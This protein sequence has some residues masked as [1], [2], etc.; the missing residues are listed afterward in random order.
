MMNRRKYLLAMAAAL[1][2]CSDAIRRR[3]THAD[4]FGAMYGDCDS[5][6]RLSQQLLSTHRS[7]ASFG[8]AIIVTA[9][10]LLKIIYN[11]LKNGWI[12]EGFT[13]FETKQNQC[14]TDNHHRRETCWTD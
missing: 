14:T 9:R 3:C 10:K 1:A 5:I 4:D 11:T 13:Q 7:T 2:L 6:F 12:F 8:K